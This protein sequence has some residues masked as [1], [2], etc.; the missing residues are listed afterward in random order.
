MGLIRCSEGLRR[1]GMTE[2]DA[3]KLDVLR[4]MKNDPEGFETFPASDA[5]NGDFLSFSLTCEERHVLWE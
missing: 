2:S 3:V 1:P 5:Q 4:V